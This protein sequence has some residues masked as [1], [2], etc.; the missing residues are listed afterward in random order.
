MG[1]SEQATPNTTRSCNA[2]A[3]HGA[4]LLLISMILGVAQIRN[5]L[6]L[7]R[8][9][10][11]E[12]ELFTF[13]QD[14]SAA[15]PSPSPSSLSSIPFLKVPE[16]SRDESFGACLMVKGDNDLLAEWIPYHYTT[17]PLRYLLV[18]S[19]VGN[20]EDPNDIVERWTRSNTGLQAWVVNASVFQ[21]L[22]G[23]FVVSEARVA[24]TRRKL[25]RRKALPDPSTVALNQSHD[26]FQQE[27]AHQRLVHLQNAF[28][29]YC[30][31]HMRQQGVRWVTLY[32]TDEFLVANRIGSDEKEGGNKRSLG[33][34][35]SK[36]HPQDPMVGPRRLLPSIESN[37][38]VLDMIHE[39]EKLRMPLKSCHTIPRLTVGA[40]ENFTCPGA[41]R[42]VSLARSNFR[43]DMLNTLRFQQH[44]VIGDFEKSRYGKVLLDIQNITKESLSGKP[45]NIHRPYKNECAVPI[46]DFWTSPFYLTHYVGSW[47]RYDGRG[48]ERR[49]AEGWKNRAYVNGS[50]ACCEDEIHRWLPRFVDQMGLDRAKFLLGSITVN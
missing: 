30:V 17:L 47:E 45:K 36:D 40:L 13:T 3:V 8:R 33:A 10:L 48:D 12:P 46:P 19:D 39:F 21:N 4:Q 43:F 49:S 23:E 32:D 16:L 24:S 22:H 11:H 15:P 20:P 38:T 27:F 2:R 14:R 37:A 44:A 31:D 9:T 41:G 26:L 50:T 1:P 25:R 18:A 28:I 42:V 29:T 6:R 5:S 35:Q 34:T 7:N